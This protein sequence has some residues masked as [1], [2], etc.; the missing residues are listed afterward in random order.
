MIATTHTTKAVV[1]TIPPSRE[2]R[3]SFKPS[4][5]NRA[6]A[7]TNQVPFRRTLGGA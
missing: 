6:A 4:H 7:C 5:Q 1:S 2:C 3:K